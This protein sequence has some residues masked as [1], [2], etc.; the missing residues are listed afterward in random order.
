MDFE[1]YARAGIEMDFEEFYERDRVEVNSKNLNEVELE[2]YVRASDDF[3]P[4]G[5]PQSY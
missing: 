2:G 4:Q 3:K 5:N 1:G